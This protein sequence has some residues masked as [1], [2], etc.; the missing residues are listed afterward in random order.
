[1]YITSVCQKSENTFFAYTN[2]C[3]S[4][5]TFNPSRYDYVY[6]IH[7]IDD[8]HN[9]FPEF[10]YDS[11]LFPGNSMITFFQMRVNE[12]FPE[13]YIRM[14]TH[15]RLYHMER[16]REA[17]IPTTPVRHSVP[18]WQ[19]PPPV[20]ERRSRPFPM[21]ATATAPTTATTATTTPTTAIPTYRLTTLLQPDT[22]AF[23]SLFTTAL[24]GTIGNRQDIADLLTPVTV[25]PTPAQ[26]NAASIVSILEPPADVTCAV[27]Q[28]HDHTS[29]EWRILRHCGHQFH[30]PCIDTWFQ[31]HVQCPVCRHD[32]REPTDET[33]ESDADESDL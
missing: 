30:R 23:T 24:F 22:D 6:G 15:Y 29:Q 12:L 33:Y 8:I 5:M 28:D 13:D 27:C 7:L 10:L 2:T 14:R 17:V 16:R 18:A 19:R 20:P 31:Q 4:N 3:T 9:L 11:G 32:I 26:I 25:A 21:A 1:M